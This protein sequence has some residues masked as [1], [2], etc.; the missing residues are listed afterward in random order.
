MRKMQRVGGVVVGMLAAALPIR[1]ALAAEAANKSLEDRVRV[2]ERKLDQEQQGDATTKKTVTDRIDTI[3]K[4]VKDNEKTLADKTGI[5]MHAM[6]AVD[7][8]YDLNAPSGSTVNG[9]SQPFL[10]TY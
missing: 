4:E 1:A 2:L 7:Y 9:F 6:V 8:L 5:S 3:E 10:R